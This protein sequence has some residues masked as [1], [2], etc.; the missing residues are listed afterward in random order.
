[1]DVICWMTNCHSLSNWQSRL[2]VTI[3]SRNQLPQRSCPAISD[4]LW[5]FV[6][7]FPQL[8]WLAVSES[9]ERERE[10]WFHWPPQIC[11]FCPNLYGVNA[12]LHFFKNKLLFIKK[13]F[14]RRNFH[15]PKCE[16]HY[17]FYDKMESA[18][19]PLDILTILYIHRILA[20]F[21]SED[22]GCQLEPN[23][24]LSAGM[25]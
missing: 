22:R 7:C 21:I 20:S 19:Y 23:D 10:R 6:K 12:S 9:R 13:F 11:N 25:E 14:N 15:F 3:M 24:S 18:G 1:M 5:Q 4:D 16:L 8:R 2:A 17:D